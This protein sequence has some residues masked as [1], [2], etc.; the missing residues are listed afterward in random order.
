MNLLPRDVEYKL[1]LKSLRDVDS[2]VAGDPRLKKAWDLIKDEHA[3]DDLRL[4][5]VAEKSKISKN[6]LNVLLRAKTGFTF[7]KLLNRYRL[8]KAFKLI[9]D[10]ANSVLNVA[11]D[12]GFGCVRTFELNFRQLF[13]F[14]PR[15]LKEFPRI[16]ISCA[17]SIS[18]LAYTAGRAQVTAGIGRLQQTWPDWAPEWLVLSVT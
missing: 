18:A 1:F 11:L 6:H 15:N 17:T 10:K 4:A 13:G 7:H 8:L 14:A 3:E 12:A 16:G 2:S 9:I 5:S